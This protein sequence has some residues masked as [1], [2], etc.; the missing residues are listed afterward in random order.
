MYRH[1][2]NRI[3]WFFARVLTSLLWW[4]M[5]LPAIGIHAPGKRNRTQRLQR[6]ARNFRAMAI[7]MGGVMIKVGQ[8]LS[9]RL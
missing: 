5:F 6:I 7:D 4:D 1:R 3:L 9:S 2:Y 8:F